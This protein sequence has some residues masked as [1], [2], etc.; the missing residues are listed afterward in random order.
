MKKFRFSIVISLI[1]PFTI[2]FF[3]QLLLF[4]IELWFLYL[5]LLLT[6]ILETFF[7][8]EEDI[9]TTNS[10]N[11]ITSGLITSSVLSIL[12]FISEHYGSHS[13]IIMY[14]SIIIIIIGI[15]LRFFA[16]LSLGSGFSHSLRIKDNHKLVTNGL[17][18]YIRHPAYSGTILLSV[19]IALNISIASSFFTLIMT[20]IGA[21][22]RIKKEEKMLVSN[23]G[24]SY[25][26]YSKKSKMLFPF[27]F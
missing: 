24:S 25:L 6:L 12:L 5:L 21:Y 13:N 15:T 1:I 17:Y 14:C 16:K 4:K 22:Y 7:L 10:D 9:S 3:V 11:G 19:G 2:T 20:C 27:I 8:K 26:N 23:F 18:A